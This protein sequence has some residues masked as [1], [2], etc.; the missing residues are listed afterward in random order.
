MHYPVAL[1]AQENRLEKRNAARR[2]LGAQAGTA[3]IIQVS[4]YEPWKG[5]LLHLNA[6]S[7]L[8]ST[9]NWVCWMV[10]GPQTAADHRHHQDVLRAAD[11]LEILDRVR[12]LGQ[13]AD[14]PQLLAGA[15]IFCQPNEGAE[16]FG[17]VFVEALWAGLPVV[18]TAMGGA[19]EILDESCGIL[20]E[21]GNPDGVANALGL[22]IGSPE[23][24]ERLGSAGP[25]RA[26]ALCD[27]AGQMGCLEQL[28][29]S[30]M[31]S[32]EA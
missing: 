20:T 14:V 6:L 11:R 4:R 16:P 27:P 31:R 30:A 12:F 23:L 1:Q 3:V 13:R 15:D 28:V 32:P 24:R 10:G 7:R 17:I 21:P 25:G 26:R 19:L 8:P 18:T 2:E 9:T 5:H 22:L 29:R